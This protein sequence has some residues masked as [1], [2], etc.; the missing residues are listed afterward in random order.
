M[1]GWAGWGSPLVLEAI[2]IYIYIY[3][4]IF[5]LH[6]S[7]LARYT[8]QQLGGWRCFGFAPKILNPAEIVQTR[9]QHCPGHED[10][11]SLGQ[12][13]TGQGRPDYEHIDSNGSA[14]K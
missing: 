9:L 2:Y 8:G 6:I 13:R 3:M 4:I 10:P 11:P 5:T 12:N 1:N 14:D 7:P